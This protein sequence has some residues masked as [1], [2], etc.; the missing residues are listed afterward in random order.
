MYARVKLDS[1]TISVTAF[2]GHHYNRTQW[3]PVPAGSE[4]EALNHPN[5][6]TLLELPAE[7]PPP[8]FD[9]LKSEITDAAVILA[10]KQNVDTSDIDGSGKEGR[11]LVEDVRKVVKARP[12]G[13]GKR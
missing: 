8:N 3:Q 5:L 2:G 12:K 6:D 10:T 1:R 4:D 13:R 7:L 9:D 11:V